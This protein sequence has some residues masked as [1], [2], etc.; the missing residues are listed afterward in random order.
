MNAKK[1]KIGSFLKER[2]SR[3][4][5]DEANE[6]GLKRVNKIDFSGVIHL[7]E[8]K[9]TKT[10]MIL[11]KK[12]DLLISGINA[13]KGGVSVYEYEE[14]AIATIHY[15]SYLYDSEKIE[16]EYLKWFLKSNTFKNILIEQAGSGIKSELKP[17]RFLPLEIVLP[18][19]SE[20]KEI[21]EKLESVNSEIE[22]LQEIGI[23]NKKLISKLRQ[24]IL[25]DAVQGK[26]TEE[27]RKQN[28]NI[29]SASELL[30]R[31]EDE[32]ELLVKEKKIKKEKQLITIRK[33]ELPFEIPENWKWCR[34]LDISNI[35]SNL[36]KPDLYLDY[37]HIAP[38]D[39]LKDRWKLLSYNT[40]RED[41]LISAKHLF[42]PGQIFYSKIR[43]H[44]NKV[45]EIDFEGLCSA[46]MYPID[47]FI[48]RGYLFR[49]MLSEV[50]VK[51]SMK[52]ESRVAMPKIN[53]SELSKILVSVP[54]IIEQEII[55]EKI[56]R[57][58]KLCDNLELE[59]NAS[60]KNADLLLQAV[61]GELI[62]EEEKLI[63]DKKIEIKTKDSQIRNAKYDS[64]TTYMELV[65]LLE[66][67]GKLHAE[68]LWKM[69]KFPNDIDSFYAE[70]KKQIEEI[71]S[72]KE[73]EKG[74]LELV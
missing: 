37:P 24:S 70:L 40:V 23:H 67:H 21:L 22:E 45:V 60:M 14:D 26:L 64:K 7:V 55:V 53:Q 20:Q 39:I 73:V 1:V 30:K 12:G 65:K 71:K 46:D 72:I 38:D 6:L 33:D 17:N 63:R 66:Q 43:P 50:F 13:E 18:T 58:M 74:Y 2:K 62:G 8:H 3:Y 68:D 57:L 19:V 27:W 29:E 56:N 44:L 36:V 42:F 10:N 54:T 59:I 15:S 28:P 34:F 5:P 52:S 4:K 9:P 41:N 61:L 51:Q 25:K 31:I 49:F 11:V 32:K 35:A 48:E 16:I 47:S 69:S